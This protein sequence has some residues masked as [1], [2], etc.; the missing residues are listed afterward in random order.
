MDEIKQGNQAENESSNSKSELVFLITI[1]K[2]IVDNKGNLQVIHPLIQ[3]NLTLLN[4]SLIKT[5]QSW[6]NTKLRELDRSNHE[7]VAAIVFVFGS[8]V[9]QFTDKNIAINVE[10]SIAL[11]RLALE[12]FIDSKNLEISRSIHN[13]LGSSYA[14]RICGEDEENLEQSIW[15]FKSAIKDLDKQNYLLDWAKINNNLAI[16]YSKRIR[17]ERSRNI[18]LSIKYFKSVVE[19]LTKQESPLEWAILQSNVATIYGDR[20]QGNKAENIEKAINYYQLSLEVLN[21][22]DYPQDWAMVKNNL[23][24]AYNDR[25][26][27]EKAENI[28]QAIEYFQA[29]LE[30]R[31]KESY[32][33]DWARTKNNIGEA[34]RN[35]IYGNRSEDIEKAIEY[36]QSALEV[37]TKQDYSQDWAMTQNNLAAAY[38]ERIHGDSTENIEKAIICYQLALEVL[39]RQNFPHHWAKIQNNLAAT[40]KNRIR[41]DRSGNL[42]KALE[43]C[44]AALEI[45]SKKNYPQDWA[46]TQSNLANIYRNR[47]KGERAE[48]LEQAIAYYRV[49]LDVHT[50]KDHPQ[51]WAMTQNNLANAYENRI[52]G[53]KADNIEL[54]I[55]CYYMALKIYTKQAFRQDWAMTHNNLAVAYCNRILGE[56]SENI[57]LAI[58]CY[59]AALEVRT[60]QDFPQ[61]WAIT[62]NNLANAYSKRISGENSENIGLA[63]ECYQSAL[64]VLTQQAFHFDCRI[65]SRNLANLHFQ[66]QQWE[67]AI[68]AYQIALDAAENLYQASI[69]LASKADEQ[70][71]TADIPRRMA[72]ALAR[73][74]NL[75]RSVEVL[76][77]NR[78]R[79]LSE[80]LDRDRANLDR[81]QQLTPRLHEEY[82][83]ITNQLRTVEEQQRDRITSADRHSL[84]PEILK[85][86]ATNLRQQLEALL[87]KIRQVDTYENFLALPT[88]EDIRSAAINERPL[89]YLVSTV[90]GSLALVVTSDKIDE[91]W[92]DNFTEIQLIS[93][94]NNWFDAYRQRA[95]ALQSW[96][97]AIDSVTHEL[98]EP[99]MAPL[100]QHLEDCKIDR[101]VL[102]PTG[103]FSLLPLHAAWTESS[104]TTT[105][106]IYALDRIHFT[107]APNAK[108]LT[109]ATAIASRVN[110]DV[111]LAIDEPKHRYQD[112]EGNYQDVRPLP[113]STREVDAAIA[114]FKNRTVLH[115]TQATRNSVLSALPHINVLHCSCHGNADLQEPLMSGLSMT[116]EG[117]SA[118]LT[119]KDLLELKLAETEMGGIR[120]AILSACETGLQGTE[121]ADEA[122]SLPT[123]LIQAGVAGVIASLWSVSDLSTMIL[124]SRFYTLWRTENLEPS[125][126]LNKAQ[127]WLRD[128]N[129]DDIINHCATFIPDLDLQIGLKR[130]LG[131]KYSAPHHWAAF[132]YVGV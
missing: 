39:N 5:T 12:V 104:E 128:A 84:T 85:D 101:A 26:R 99:L 40:Y 20:I 24:V 96:F 54:A 8:V 79:G 57:D 56:S 124:V 129:P 78:A 41:E 108:S 91:I 110:A 115:Q 45:Y 52:R 48:N 9:E 120:L 88:F 2:A 18:E 75:Q 37:R 118:T 131:L 28:E 61:D 107:Y 65:T 93:L 97:H 94:V 82:R 58:E 76:E 125:I 10:I 68:M 90:A 63:I 43:Y 87:Q 49:S 6:F 112:N 17:G 55:D 31:T 46:I 13:S 109:A 105:G 119:I 21:K 34:Y 3:A 126:A 121:N 67:S 23:A 27:G 15:H 51:D 80:S 74:G 60:R 113:N 64:D 72:Y 38:H 35:R 53:E 42:E 25:I 95:D 77:Q 114:T 123:G 22:Q 4:E 89:V 106:R 7:H 59:Q 50:L 102:I 47:I 14:K 73:T 71:E 70:K 62:Q 111:M 44:Q 116:G 36:F 103:Y 11:Y 69:L 33:Q 30:V 132:H 32:P 92:L 122:I 130:K 29:A 81:L 1:L 16:V 100:I 66:Q 86:T 98:W 83:D 127:K 117:A 19:I